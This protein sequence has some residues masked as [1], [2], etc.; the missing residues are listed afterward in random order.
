M[1]EKV[2]KDHLH[3]IS[4]MDNMPNTALTSPVET[5]GVEKMFNITFRAAILNES[6]SEW[7]TWKENTC[8]VK[9]ESNDYE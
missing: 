2:L 3:S 6:I 5:A 9:S 4:F 1:H 8:Y 7:A